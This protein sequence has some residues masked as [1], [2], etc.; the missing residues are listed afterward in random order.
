MALYNKSTQ[1][2]PGGTYTAD[3]S[4]GFRWGDGAAYFGAFDTAMPPNSAMCFFGGAATHWVDVWKAASSRHTGG[5]QC[6]MMDGSVRFISEN[7][8]CGNLAAAPPGNVTRT[9][10]AYG[11]GGARGTKQGGEVVGDV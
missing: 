3:T 9:P 8:N 7:I 2:Y 4:P 1:T 10:S 6:L 5:V 11:I